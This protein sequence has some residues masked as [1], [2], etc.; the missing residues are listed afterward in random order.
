MWQQWVNAV[1][2]LWV[3]ILPL[4][5]LTGSAALWIPIAT[6]AMITVLSVWAAGRSAIADGA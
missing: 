6:G 4:L 2:G 3:I 5:N 1:L